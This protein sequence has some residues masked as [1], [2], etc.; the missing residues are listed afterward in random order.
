MTNTDHGL[1][2][3]DRF[4]SAIYWADDDITL[5]AALTEAIDDWIAQAAAEYNDSE[6]FVTGQGNDPLA[7]SLIDLVAAVER[8][9]AGA[10]PGLSV[11]SAVGEALDDWSRTG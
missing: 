2:A 5:E 10:R 8:L 11:A 4:V 6:P 9:A 3:L 7:R 1:V